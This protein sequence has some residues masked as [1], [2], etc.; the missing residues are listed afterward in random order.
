[1][2][3]KNCKVDIV[4]VSVE[5]KKNSTHKLDF[6]EILAHNKVNNK[7][8]NLRNKLVHFSIVENND[9]YIIR[10]CKSNH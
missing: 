1:M 2:S 4:K 8:L 10:F 3:N 5:H 7:E 6:D 9:S